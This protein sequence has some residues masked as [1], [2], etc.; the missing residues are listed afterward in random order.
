MENRIDRQTAHPAPLVLTHRAL[1]VHAAIQFLKWTVTFR[2]LGCCAA[3]LVSELIPHEPIGWLAVVLLFAQSA[4]TSMTDLRGTY[5]AFKRLF[6]DGQ[7]ALAVGL[8][9]VDN[10]ALTQ[11]YLA[12]SRLRFELLEVF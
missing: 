9:A 1:H 7:N 4:A 11:S 5:I 6:S 8:R 2:T 3:L 12:S 10:L